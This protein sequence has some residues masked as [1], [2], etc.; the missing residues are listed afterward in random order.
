[1]PE[2]APGWNDVRRIADELE[3]KIHL[4]GMEARD[5]WRAL[6]PRIAELETKL[7]S[8]SERTGR[9][10]ADELSSIA[11]AIRRLRDDITTP[12]GCCGGDKDG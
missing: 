11:T 9:L 5:R 6:Q 7:A 12:G 3:L 8:A 10:V 1:M 2:A 4:A